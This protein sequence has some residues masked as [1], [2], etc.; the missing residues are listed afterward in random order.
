MENKAQK[1]LLLIYVHEQEDLTPIITGEGWHT[2]KDLLNKTG[3]LYNTDWNGNY[4]ID[5]DETPWKATTEEIESLGITNGTVVSLIGGDYRKKEKAPIYL[6]KDGSA[7]IKES[8]ATELI[9]F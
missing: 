7:Y 8:D 4:V 3:T 5:L 2:I 9:E 1:L 6:D